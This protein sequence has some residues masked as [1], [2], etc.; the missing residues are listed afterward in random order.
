LQQ[1]YVKSAERQLG[2]SSEQLAVFQKANTSNPDTA[3]SV[4][5]WQAQVANDEFT[6]TKYKNELKTAQINL[7]T[8]LALPDPLGI[9]IAEIKDETFTVDRP[10]GQ[11]KGNMIC[12]IKWRTGIRQP[13]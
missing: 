12:F 8:L 4:L 9:E 10:I 11:K 13:K 7:G 6:L 3:Y 2:I 5:E 1:V